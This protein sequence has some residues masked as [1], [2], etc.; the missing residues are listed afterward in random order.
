MDIQKF[1]NPAEECAEIEAEDLDQDVLNEFTHSPEFRS[2]EE[3][4]EQPIIKA[5]EALEAAKVLELWHLQKDI[6]EESAIES[7]RKQISQLEVAR[8]VERQ[9][10][11]QG[12]LDNW[13][14][15]Q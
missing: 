2:D 13:L 1:I 3:V 12:K 5:H 6:S 11:R 14:V 8:Q 15:K 4:E 10:G 9:V 7:I